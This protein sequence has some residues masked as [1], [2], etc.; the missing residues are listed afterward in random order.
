MESYLRISQILDLAPHR[1]PMA[2]M[3]EVIMCAADHGEC[4]VQLKADGHYMSGK[5][6][7]ATSL[8]EFVAQGYGFI[9]IAH[10]IEAHG[11]NAKPLKR[12]FLAAFSEAKFASPQ[13]IRSLSEGDLINIKISGIRR[14]GPIAAFKGTVV[15]GDQ[16][17]CQTKMKIYSER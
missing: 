10:E 2:W 3:D 17:I 14:I 6:L 13:V 8:L 16:Q 5:H 1:P 7:R 15:C 9:N 12:A 11:D 4:R